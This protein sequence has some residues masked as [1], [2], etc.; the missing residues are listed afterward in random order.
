MAKSMK[1]ISICC[2][3]L[4][5]MLSSCSGGSSSSSSTGYIDP[6]LDSEKTVA[7]KSYTL[8]TQSCSSSKDCGDI[9]FQGEIDNTNYV[10]CMDNY[11]SGGSKFSLKIYWEG[12]SIPS[13][14]NNPAGYVVE[15]TIGTNKYTNSNVSGNLRATITSGTDANGVT[16]YTI[17][18]NDSLTIGSL[19][20][21]N[22]NSIVAYKY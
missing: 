21:T 1:Y 3:S 7:L 19:N 4:G 8:G 13:S 2:L 11:Q 14:I 18:F 10:A 22:G 9:I 5:L 17:T 6:G 12:S 15:A 20:I 16:V